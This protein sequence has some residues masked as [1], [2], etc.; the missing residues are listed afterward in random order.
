[1]SNKELYTNRKYEYW[2]TQIYQ[3]QISTNKLR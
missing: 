2:E 3:S 1:M